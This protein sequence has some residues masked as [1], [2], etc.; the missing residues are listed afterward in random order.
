MFPVGG[1]SGGGKPVHG[2]ERVFAWLDYDAVNDKIVKSH[3]I[4]GVTVGAPGYYFVD[5]DFS[6]SATD[7][8]VVVGQCFGNGYVV[9][10]TVKN[11]IANN[12]VTVETYD[13]GDAPA[14]PQR[15]QFIVVR[16]EPSS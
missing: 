4:L 10:A 13:Q 16:K 3:N 9:D 12:Q 11:T 1:G 2:E 5:I 14:H 8:L 7:E 6:G 15:F